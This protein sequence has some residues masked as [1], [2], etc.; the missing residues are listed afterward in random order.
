VPT[1]DQPTVTIVIVP[2]ESFGYARMSL[3]SL[4]GHTRQPFE[5][6]YV[7]GGSPRQ[8][9]DYLAG[10][11][12]AKGFK[13]IRTEE[14][15]SPNRARN[16][17]LRAATTRYVVFADNDIL[18]QEGWLER[19]VDTAESTGAAIVGPLCCIGSP[20][21]EIIHNGGGETTIEEKEKKGRLV[22]RISQ[23]THLSGH[24]VSESA[25]ELF[26]F[27]CDYVEFHTVLVRRSL[28]DEIGE[29][30]EKLLSTREHIDLCMLAKQAGHSIYC[31]R[32]AAITYV[33]GVR[34]SVSDMSYFMLR[35]SDAWDLASLDH[36]RTKWGLDDDNYFQKRYGKLG[37][38]RHRAMIEPIVSRMP[39]AGELVE[40][41][42]KAID[43]R[44]SSS[45]VERYG[46]KHDYA[47]H[48][49]G[50]GPRPRIKVKTRHGLPSQLAA[51]NQ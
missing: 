11:A 32:R 2:R 16:I 1:T 42:L 4:Y 39:F 47:R 49:V 8:V 29:L 51:S 41:M 24:R 30:D 28:F 5:L 36:F 33:P 13:L 43:R 20:V 17:G 50:L 18:F 7:D 38:R 10:Q 3:E 23:Q 6:V 44:W 25:S 40:R 15:L 26:P 12:A 19:L 35:W 27:K 14:Y 22:R 31:E 21:H 34:P 48:S 45:V 46:K 9:R 37:K